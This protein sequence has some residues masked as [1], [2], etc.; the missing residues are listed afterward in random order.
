MPQAAFNTGTTDDLVR[1]PLASAPQRL[2]RDV[3]RD[4]NDL[5]PED[6]DRV[7]RVLAD[8]RAHVDERNLDLYPQFRDFDRRN[9]FT[10]GVTRAQFRR[11]LDLTLSLPLADGDIKL[12]CDKYAS[13]ATGHINYHK[14]I[15]DVD[16]D[17]NLKPKDDLYF[18][19]TKIA[20]FKTL[21]D[22]EMERKEQMADL[23]EAVALLKLRFAP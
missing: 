4:D 18:D 3:V 22:A 21:K 2:R 23:N 6:E 14:F 15:A 1:N 17:S 8:I 9:G 16:E 12:I 5:S 20:G 11:L 13:P 10:K 7:Q 19:K